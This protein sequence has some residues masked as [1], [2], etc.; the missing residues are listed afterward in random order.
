MSTP[1]RPT[2]ITPRCYSVDQV[3]RGTLFDLFD[4]F[5]WSISDTHYDPHNKWF[6]AFIVIYR[7]LIA[8]AF[9]AVAARIGSM[10]AARESSARRG[11]RDEG[12]PVETGGQAR[13][14]A[15]AGRIAARACFR[16]ATSPVRTSR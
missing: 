9:A 2:P 6:S 13:A 4:V 12:A 14:E 15:H 1:T 16:S 8:A 3:L 7:L 11:G 10:R 5:D